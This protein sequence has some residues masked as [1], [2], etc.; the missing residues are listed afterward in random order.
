MND[1]FPSHYLRKARESADED[2]EDEDDTD[3][4]G[5]GDNDDD[6]DA[7][8]VYLEKSQAPR[9]KFFREFSDDEVAEMWQVH[10]FMTFVSV[11]VQYAMP[12]SGRYT[13]ASLALFL[14]Y[15]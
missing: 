13:C 8:D 1:L 9:R 10:N 14:L 4:D 11:R 12:F 15:P 2:D 5:G 6:I 7:P 3:G